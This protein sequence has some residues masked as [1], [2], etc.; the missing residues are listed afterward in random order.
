V[1]TVVQQGVVERVNDQ[2]R[3]SFTLANDGGQTAEAVQVVAELSQNGE[4]I[5]A[6]E[7]QIDF[8][9]VGEQEEGAFL[10]TQNPSQAELSI[11]VASYKLP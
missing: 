10:F 5:E 7:Q 6:G 1:F 2:F 11:R 3:V 8:L 9:S 4:V